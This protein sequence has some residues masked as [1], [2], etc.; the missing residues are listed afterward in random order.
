[1]CDLFILLFS[2]FNI[3]VRMQLDEVIEN[4][5]EGLSLLRKLVTAL[6]PA[7][8]DLYDVLPWPWETEDDLSEACWK[9]ME[10]ADFRK[11]LV[12]WNIGHN[13]YNVYELILKRGFVTFVKKIT[14][15]T[16]QSYFFSDLLL[17]RHIWQIWLH[18]TICL[19]AFTM[20]EYFFVA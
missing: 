15:Q 12:S 10:N 16:F 1:M 18:G 17:S 8:D 5:H 3:T 19:P 7:T 20:Y 2:D 9:I 11:K 4:Q 6:A 14:A 13:N